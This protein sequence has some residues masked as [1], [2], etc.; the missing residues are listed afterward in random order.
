MRTRTRLIAL[1]AAGA[2]LVG[3]GST[4]AGTGVLGSVAGAPPTAADPA[5]PQEPA[6]TTEDAPAD[7]TTEEEPPAEE[8]TAEEPTEEAPADDPTVELPEPGDIPTGLPGNL[9]ACLSVSL[10]YLSIAFAA[11]ST[12]ASELDQVLVDIDTALASAPEEIK[13]ALQ[14]LADLSRQAQGKPVEEWSAIL[15]S[16][17][18]TAASEEVSAWMASAC[19]G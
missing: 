6:E 8:P 4:T 3:C 13:P 16:P 12:D 1:V 10:A 19:E 2:L 7:A 11:F 14:T 17:E 15:G 9:D 5:D 18:Y